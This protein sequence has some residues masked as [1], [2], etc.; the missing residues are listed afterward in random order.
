[1]D[2]INEAIRLRGLFVQRYSGVEWAIAALILYAQQHPAY[3]EFEGL[4][5]S[6]SGKASKLSRVEKLLD[7][8]GP[9]DPHA[10]S[11]R[12]YLQAFSDLD[13]RRNF[14]VH[15]IMTPDRS[16]HGI[17][18]FRFAM[19]R[20]TKQGTDYGSMFTTLAELEALADAVQP[21]STGVTQL[22]ASILR[23]LDVMPIVAIF[24]HDAPPPFGLELG[25]RI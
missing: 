10:S 15:A 9:L 6:W 12:S 24:D 17:T 2:E 20:P 8:G 13:E 25:A 4:P 7:H 5:W 1:M 14:L 22:V 19:F 16:H 3:E 23:S 21:I 18:R 11:I